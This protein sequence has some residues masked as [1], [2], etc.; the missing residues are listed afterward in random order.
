[1]ANII[2]A[3]NS[4]NGGTAITTDTSGTLNIVT[5]S[6]SGSNAITIDAS[7]AVTMPG[8]LAVTGAQTVGGNLTVTGTLTASGGVTGSITRGT[9]VSASGTSVSFTGIPS[10]VKRITVMFN[11]VSTSGSSLYLIQLGT[12]GGVVTT[13]YVGSTGWANNAASSSVTNVTAGIGI[14]NDNAG[15]AIYGSVSILNITSNTWVAS[16]TIGWNTTFIGGTGSSI[17]LGGTLDRLRITTVNG[18][19][20]FD[21]GTVNIL[22]E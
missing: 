14:N 5:G 10:G 2:T 9:A 3:G 19:D 15:R 1:M 13:G 22:W 12:S 7:Q 16:G 20:T 11:G 4:T 18:T 21:A 17:A 8:T 6:G